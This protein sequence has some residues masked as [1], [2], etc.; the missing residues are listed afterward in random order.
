MPEEGKSDPAK[1]A[2]VKPPADP[3]TAPAEKPMRVQT[4]DEVK[5]QL[6]REMALAPARQKMNEQIEKVRKQMGDYFIEKQLYDSQDPKN[7]TAPKP[8]ELDLKTIAEANGPLLWTYRF[9]RY[10][11]GARSPDRKEPDQFR[12][13]DGR[14]MN[15]AGFG[16]S[17]LSERSMFLYGSQKCRRGLA[18]IARGLSCFGRS[19]KSHLESCHLKRLVNKS[20]PHGRFEK[21]ES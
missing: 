4:L 8:T 2:E 16:E 5:D 9:D 10:G 11:F 21:Q 17:V 20:W 19:R 18:W 7:R 12:G 14:S 13:M 15:F 6:K 1:P 3:A